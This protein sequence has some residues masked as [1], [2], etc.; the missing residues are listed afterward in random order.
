MSTV[1]RP[2]SVEPDWIAEAE[3]LEEEKNR[4][5]K[6]KNINNN[7]NNNNNT[8]SNTR[9]KTTKPSQTALN[10]PFKAYLIGFG[11]PPNEQS[12]VKRLYETFCKYIFFKYI[13]V[14]FLYL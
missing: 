7:N 13:F 12:L 5:K 6:M 14:F 2:T 3:K 1:N 10:K 9:H 11:A 4:K 8:T